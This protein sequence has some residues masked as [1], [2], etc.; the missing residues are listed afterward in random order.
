MDAGRLQGR[1]VARCH[2]DETQGDQ[3]VV[4]QAEH[5]KIGTG[6]QDLPLSAAEAADQRK[7]R[8]R[9]ID[10]ADF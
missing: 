6:A 9:P 1:P 10:Y 4:S 5:L 7:R 8:P 2:A 3:G